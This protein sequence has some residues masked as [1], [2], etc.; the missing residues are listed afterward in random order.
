MKCQ[1]LY[2][3]CVQGSSH[4]VLTDSVEGH[5]ISVFKDNTCEEVCES[6]PMW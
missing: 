4:S 3:K 1:Y 6:R 2:N 5:Q